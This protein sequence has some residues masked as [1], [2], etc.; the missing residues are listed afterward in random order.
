[1][2]NRQRQNRYK[3][4]A[5]SFRCPKCRSTSFEMTEHW[6][7]FAKHSTVENSKIVDTCESIGDPFK[8]SAVCHECNHEWVFRGLNQ[9]PL[10]FQRLTLLGGLI[11]P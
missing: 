5:T 11:N 7:G 4:P 9:I 10:C 3:S 2:T 8:V 6:N 1:M